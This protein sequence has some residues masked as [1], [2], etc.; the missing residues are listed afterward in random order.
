MIENLLWLCFVLLVV[1]C[2]NVLYCRRWNVLTILKV[3]ELVL[4]RGE[5]AAQAGRALVQAQRDDADGV[6]AALAAQAG[7]AVLRECGRRGRGWQVAADWGGHHLLLPSPP[8]HGHHH[9]GVPVGGGRP[10]DVQGLGGGRPLGGAA[11]DG[12]AKCGWREGGVRL[13]CLERK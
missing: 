3:E 7:Q 10:N 9:A 11:R 8:K 2:Y 12:G 13:S 5:V 4:P 1:L 6:D